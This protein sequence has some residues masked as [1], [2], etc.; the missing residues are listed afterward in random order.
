MQPALYSDNSVSCSKHV[1]SVVDLTM[2]SCCVRMAYSNGESGIG[3]A[4]VC[5]NWRYVW[6]ITSPLIGHSFPRYLW[7]YKAGEVDSGSD[8][9]WATRR[10]CDHSHCVHSICMHDELTIMQSPLT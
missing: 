3:Q 8:G 6:S 1:S 7:V 2:V 4:G 10:V 5:N 9:V